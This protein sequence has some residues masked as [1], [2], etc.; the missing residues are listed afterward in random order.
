M[1]PI[2]HSRELQTTEFWSA[3]VG[4][5]VQITQALHSVT[6]VVPLPHASVEQFSDYVVCGSIFNQSLVGKKLCEVLPHLS[7]TEIVGR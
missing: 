2:S 4:E 6:S 1:G 7:R 5:F 3:P